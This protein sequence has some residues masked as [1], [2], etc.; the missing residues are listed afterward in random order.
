VKDDQPLLSP[1]AMNLCRSIIHEKSKEHRELLLIEIGGTENHLHVAAKIPP[2]LLISDWIGEIKGATS[3]GIKRLT[4]TGN[5]TW[6]EGY[7]VISFREKEIETV[8]NYI[9]N[10]AEHHASGKIY[11]DL[12]KTT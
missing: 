6:Q 4:E 5:F 12:E 11:P 2:T 7:G 10:Q 1:G 8:R 3:F 9:K